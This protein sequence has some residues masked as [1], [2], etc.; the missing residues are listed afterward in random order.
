MV[1]YKLFPITRERRTDTKTAKGAEHCLFG[2][3]SIDD[4]IRAITICEG[5]IDAMS[6]YQYGYAAL[7]VPFGAGVGHKNDWIENDWTLLERFEKIYLAMDEPGQKAARDIARR[8][9]IHRCLI[10]SLP[11]K[12]FN[13]CL[14]KGVDKEEI[15]LKYQEAEYIDPGYL[16]NI[17]HFTSAILD[18]MD[19]SGKKDFYSPIFHS[20]LANLKL[21]P[22]E[23]T[24][25]GGFSGSGKTT[26]L[27]QIALDTVAQGHK[28]CIA[29]LEQRPPKY[30]KKIIHQAALKKDVM[31]ETIHEIITWLSGSIYVYDHVGSVD[32]ENLFM[33]MEYAH[34]R[35]GVKFFIIDSLVKCGFAEDDYNGQK[36]F[37]E[38]LTNLAL[39]F[40]VHIYLVVHS[41]KKDSER[42]QIGKMDIKGSGA[43]TD[44]ASNVILIL[45]NK[46]KERQIDVEGKY[47]NEADMTLIV[48]KQREFGW[49]GSI[50]FM[51]DPNCNQYYDNKKGPIN[52]LNHLQKKEYSSCQE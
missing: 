7:S 41:R 44:L 5:E 16:K 1:N 38:S 12:D 32:R 49:E 26:F 47:K 35:F 46:E 8:L 24:I 21:W 34:R 15:D 48:D 9:G 11:W 3:Q 39:N 42:R 51:Y 25:V 10:V 6:A 37:V 22:G 17:D 19:N 28:I 36:I 27:M 43:I 33:A 29:S 30:L 31:P 18:E 13:E 45:R 4:N 52:Y 50:P 20:K 14:M 23:V 2:W 40:G